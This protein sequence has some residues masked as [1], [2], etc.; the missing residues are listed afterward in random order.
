MNLN[1]LGQT[2]L[3]EEILRYQDVSTEER[4]ISSEEQLRI[5]RERAVA[6]GQ[7]LEGTEAETEHIEIAEFI[8]A[9]EKYGI[10]TSYIEEVH[11][12]KDYTPIPCTPDYVFGIIN[13]RGKIISVI[14]L[15]KFFD[16]PEKGLTDLNKVIIIH[17]DSM[18][19][20]ILSDAILG[21]RQI[22]SSELQASLPT[23]TDIRSDYLKGIT[24]ERLIVLDVRKLLTNEKL[25]VHEEV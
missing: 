6:L 16:L 17:N 19:F 24:E 7:V 14:N 22:K 2:P 13:L 20:G 18:E 5:L 4:S 9:S 1:K 21:V 23:L 12:L 10:E 8:L 15:K 3:Q 25:I 11:P